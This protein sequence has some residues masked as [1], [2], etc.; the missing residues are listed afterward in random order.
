M[1]SGQNEA[2]PLQRR[3]SNFY[4]N[5]NNQEPG[6]EISMD[7][8]KLQIDNLSKVIAK[9]E[10]D[11]RRKDKEQAKISKRRYQCQTASFSFLGLVCLGIVAFEVLTHLEVLKIHRIHKALSPTLVPVKQTPQPI[12]TSEWLI[13]PTN[14]ILV[15][16]GRQGGKSSE[17]LP[18]FVSAYSETCVVPDLPSNTESNFLALHVDANG[19]KKV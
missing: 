3:E 9:T 7:A 2:I 5:L 17:V 13:Q 15:V 4:S 8:I 18:H 1:I 14:A 10:A 12:Q 11:S 19:E 16:G 6:P